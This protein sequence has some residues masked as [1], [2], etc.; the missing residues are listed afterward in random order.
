MVS[1]VGYILGNNEFDDNQMCASDINQ[2]SNIDVL[3][4][5]SIVNNILGN[6]PPTWFD[7][8]ADQNGDGY[9]DVSYDAGAQSG[10]LNLDGAGDVLDVVAMVYNILNP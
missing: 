1:I 5:V 3:D 10:D 4:I 9:D 2:D 7:C 8:S 6:T